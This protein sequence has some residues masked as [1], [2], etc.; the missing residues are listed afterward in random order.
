MCLAVGTGLTSLHT[1]FELPNN[2]PGGDLNGV[3]IKI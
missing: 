2:F 1:K 3:H